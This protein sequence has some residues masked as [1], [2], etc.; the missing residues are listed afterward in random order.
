MTQ[1]KYIVLTE[2]VEDE[3]PEGINLVSQVED[4]N[5]RFEVVLEG[6]Q[7]TIESFLSATTEFRLC[8]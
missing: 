1:L 8:K 6:E 7:E 3:L 4:D 5:F 2:I